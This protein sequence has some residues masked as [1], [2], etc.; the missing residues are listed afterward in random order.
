MT[1]ANVPQSYDGPLVWIVETGEWVLAECAAG[2]VDDPTLLGLFTHC[3]TTVG[4]PAVV[5]D[6]APF[7]QDVAVAASFERILGGTTDCTTGPG[8]CVLALARMETQRE[9][10]RPH[11]AAG[12]RLTR[13]PR[14]P[15]TGG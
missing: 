13:D 1:G 4:G 9:G 11:H 14:R 2:I 7:S 8:T 3:G 15:V 6:W 12:V 10:D 5:D